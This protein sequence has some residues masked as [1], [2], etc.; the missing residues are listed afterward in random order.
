M[1][2]LPQRNELFRSI[3]FCCLTVSQIFFHSQAVP[4][5]QRR[6]G[7]GSIILNC[8]PAALLLHLFYIR[9]ELSV[10]RCC[11]SKINRGNFSPASKR[12]VYPILTAS[13][14][15]MMWMMFLLNAFNVKRRQTP[16]RVN[17]CVRERRS[18]KINSRYPI[19]TFAF[20]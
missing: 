4:V 8:C 9:I 5:R 6:G 17:L 3:V 18:S 12:A 20:S 2:F 15:N 10:E 19:F 16:P 7:G 11:C 13:S 14:T 1:A